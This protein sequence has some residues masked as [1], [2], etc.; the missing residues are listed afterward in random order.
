M[1]HITQSRPWFGLG[2]QVKVVETKSGRARKAGVSPRLA[3]RCEHATYQTVKARFITS[4]RN[5]SLA[6]ISVSRLSVLSLSSPSSLSLDLNSS[7]CCLENTAHIRP[8]RSVS[9][10]G[11][12]ANVLKPLFARKRYGPCGCFCHGLATLG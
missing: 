9:G 2:F 1:A 3:S 10:R 5:L 7:L 8:S 12:K 4:T 6:C 11:F